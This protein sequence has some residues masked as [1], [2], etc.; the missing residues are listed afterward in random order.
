MADD[1]DE[2]AL[3]WEQDQLQKLEAAAQTYRWKETNPQYKQRLKLIQ[4]QTLLRMQRAAGVEGDAVPASQA[5][6]AGAR[7]R[8]RPAQVEKRPPVTGWVPFEGGRFKR[9]KGFGGAKALLGQAPFGE[10]TTDRDA[11]GSGP[12]RRFISIDESTGN[13]ERRRI[14]RHKGAA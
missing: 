4:Q 1:A 7:K 13:F 14:K 5:N 8:A 3:A 6:R 2:D 12:Y 9:F 10:W 11:P